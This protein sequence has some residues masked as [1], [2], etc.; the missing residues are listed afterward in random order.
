MIAKTISLAIPVPVS[1]AGGS[2]LLICRELLRYERVK[3]VL[4]YNLVIP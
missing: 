1:F 3:Q 2:A 4:L